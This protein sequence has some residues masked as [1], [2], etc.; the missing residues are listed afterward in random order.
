MKKLFAKA[1]TKL[2]FARA[3]RF[4]CLIGLIMSST[5]HADV[6]EIY[7][8]SELSPNRVIGRDREL[9]PE[10][11]HHSLINHMMTP[12]HPGAFIVASASEQEAR[13]V[14]AARLRGRPGGFG[15]IY[16]VR[17]DESFY[18]VRLSFQHFLD[19]QRTLDIDG[20][21]P[22]LEA[23]LQVMINRLG[24]Q[25]VYAAT[26]SIGRQSIISSNRVRGQDQPGAGFM[27]MGDGVR[28]NPRYRSGPVT[29]VNPRPYAMSWPQDTSLLG[30]LWVVEGE[31]GGW[32][33]GALAV[34][35]MTTGGDWSS[36]RRKRDEDDQEASC[37]PPPLTD[38]WR[39]L[40]IVAM[41][42][43]VA[44]GGSSAGPWH[45]EL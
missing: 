21:Y 10:G 24:N 17:A 3:S 43:S 4:A 19:Q 27:V 32:V 36:H 18:D 40:K 25:P 31:P 26:A 42:S 15:Y 12:D 23:A 39:R 9:R 34:Q 38:L 2:S 37:T 14:A 8:Y 11:S 5:S 29:S 20:R 45:D 7:I 33:Q 13:R 35:C 1:L 30:H 28:D 16:R 22:G 6:N 41:M 44:S